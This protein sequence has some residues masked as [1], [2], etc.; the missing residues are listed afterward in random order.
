MG[1]NPEYSCGF[2]AFEIMPIFQNRP[3]LKPF[4][5]QMASDKF[6]YSGRERGLI[7]IHNRLSQSKTSSS[8]NMWSFNFL[9]VVS[10]HY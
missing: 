8:R 1:Y 2:A 3:A 6:S 7:R 10:H 4:G 5:F 9:V